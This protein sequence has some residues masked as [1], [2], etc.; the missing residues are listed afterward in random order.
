MTGALGNYATE[1]AYSSVIPHTILEISR[2][3]ASIEILRQRIQEGFQQI[4]Q[5]PVIF[6]TMIAG[7]HSG[8]GGRGAGAAT[9]R[10]DRER[11][12]NGRG[13]SNNLSQWTAGDL[14][15]RKAN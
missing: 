9:Q 7:L 13:S 12:E 8:G 10:N 3:I 1:A 14:D 11:I 4:R 15:V 5:T 6:E 2:P